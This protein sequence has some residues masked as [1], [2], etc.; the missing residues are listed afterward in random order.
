MDSRFH[1]AAGMYLSLSMDVHTEAGCGSHI[2]SS[3]ELQRLR[4]QPQ[5]PLRKALLLSSAPG[6]SSWRGAGGGG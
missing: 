4:L 2:E 6:A 3:R 1:S 5:G